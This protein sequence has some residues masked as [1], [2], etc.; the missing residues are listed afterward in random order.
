[1]P[2]SEEDLKN[3]SPEELLE[4]QKKNCIFCRIIKGDVPSKKVYEDD[5][6]LA[7]LDINPANVGHI[8]LLPK[9]H[10]SVMP[11]IPDD[12]I[13][14]LFVVS[15]YLSAALI[16]TIKAKG[17]NIFVANG[18]AAGQRAPHFMIHI[19]PRFE[20]DNISNFNLPG[21]KVDEKVLTAIQ[22]ALV[23]FLKK[24]FSNDKEPK[25]KTVKHIDEKE[26]LGIDLSKLSNIERRFSK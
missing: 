25:Q 20:G 16:K 2:I 22:S 21:Y 17:V 12:L 7:I 24:Q 23:G 8:L 19:I 9:E 11:Q 13:R 15:K 3:M 6:V 5:K 10:Y 14:Y 1:M 4:Y 18:S 26:D